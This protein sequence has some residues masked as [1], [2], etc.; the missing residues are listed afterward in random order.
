[1]AHNMEREV[2]GEFVTSL[3]LAHHNK[4]LKR[5]TS[6]TALGMT[7]VTAPCYSS[8]SFRKQR[9]IHPGG[10][11]ACQPNRRE[12]KRGLQPNIGLF[13]SVFSPPLGPALWKPGQPGVLFIL[14]VVLTLVLG[15]SFL[16][17]LQAFP[18]FVF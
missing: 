3:V 18:F 14:P 7:S 17:I 8:V 10:V 6:V 5:Q 1:M 12:E 16:L 4:N 2:S 15:P 13:F 11:R 9:K